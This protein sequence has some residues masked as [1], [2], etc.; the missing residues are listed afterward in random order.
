MSILQ[1]EPILARACSFDSR[2]VA[3][4]GI[5]SHVP[6]LIGRLQ[7]TVER[8]DQNCADLAR[9]DGV[10]NTVADKDTFHK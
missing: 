3:E 1:V 2:K 4:G 8:V 7:S 6:V 10:L 9:I 5:A